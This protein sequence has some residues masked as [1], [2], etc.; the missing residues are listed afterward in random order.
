MLKDPQKF[1]LKSSLKEFPKFSIKSTLKGRQKFFKKSTL[2]DLQKLF[3]KSTG[4][5][6]GISTWTI[7]QKYF[8]DKS[9]SIFF[10]N[11]Y[12]LILLKKSNIF[13]HSYALDYFDWQLCCCAFICWIPNEFCPHLWVHHPQPVTS[14]SPPLNPKQVEPLQ[15]V[16]FRLPSLPSHSFSIHT[17]QMQRSA[18]SNHCF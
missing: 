4:N 15:V 13:S 3:I 12:F 17:Q 10:F 8:T 11:I 9:Y 7:L 18:Q 14:S 2:K 16:S 5:S 6:E 1:S